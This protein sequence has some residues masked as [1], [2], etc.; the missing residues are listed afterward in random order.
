M[1]RTWSR[2]HGWEQRRAGGWE[3]PQR[4]SQTFVTDLERER[5]ER[6]ARLEALRQLA[7]AGVKRAHV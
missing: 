1:A 7:A 5:R 3:D 2:R 6:E 4:Y